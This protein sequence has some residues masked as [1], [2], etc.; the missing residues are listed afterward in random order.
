MF[1]RGFFRILGRGNIVY[2]GFFNVHRN[3]LFRRFGPG[4]HMAPIAHAAPAPAAPVHVA[5]AFGA[6]GLG[7]FGAFG[8]LGGI[9]GL[10]AF[11]GLGPVGPVGH[12]PAVHAPAMHA[13]ANPL[14]NF[15]NLFGGPNQQNFN[16]PNLQNFLQNNPIQPH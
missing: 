6:P 2:R 11:G 7:A 5:P 14:N 16:P 15:H 13:P 9:G 3:H 8:G 1:A 4:H 12:A 10:G